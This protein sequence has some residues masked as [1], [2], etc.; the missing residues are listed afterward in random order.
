MRCSGSLCTS[1]CRRRPERDSTTRRGT[2]WRLE[3]GGSAGRYGGLAHH[4]GRAAPLGNAAPAF[5]YALEAAGEAESLLSFDLAARRFE[6]ALAMLA[7]DPGMGDR[8]EVK[9]ALGDA[10]AAAGS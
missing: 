4:F 10:L 1:C 8:I 3:G 7:I 9:L 6:Q 2:S 5:R